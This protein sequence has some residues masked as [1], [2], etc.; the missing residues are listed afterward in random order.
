MGRKRD[1]D[2]RHD[3]CQHDVIARAETAAQGG[4]C[5]Q[6]P[7]EKADAV[8]MQ[9]VQC[10]VVG[11]NIGRLRVHVYP[12]AAFTSENQSP[13]PEYAAAAAEVQHPL[14]RRGPVLQ[15]LKAESCRG[16]TAGAEG[17]PRVQPQRQPAAI[18]NLFPLG[19]DNKLAADR[20]GPVVVAP[21]VFP[22]AVLHRAVL[23]GREAG[24]QLTQHPLPLL[25]VG[26]IELQAADPVKTLFQFGIDIIPVLVIVFQKAPEILLALQD[27][28]A[29][30]ERGKLI[31]AAVDLFLRRIQNA[32]DITH[33]CL[34]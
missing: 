10:G 12:E 4:V 22:V 20:D 21:V 14:A 32:F 18:R 7:G 31:A 5:Q 30:P 2:I 13:D 1:D 8:F 15:R 26:Q 17:K 29:D 28:T 33:R 6:I 3:V 16:V 19:Y 24:Q 34:L 9:T 27:E 11:C 25:V 23:N